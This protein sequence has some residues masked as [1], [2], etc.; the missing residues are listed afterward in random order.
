VLTIS[1]ETEEHDE[2]T[3]RTYL[4]RERRFGARCVGV[5]FTRP[6]RLRESW[7]GKQVENYIAADDHRKAA[8]VSGREADQESACC[9]RR[10][11]PGLQ[12]VHAGGGTR[13]PDT[14]IMM[15]ARW[16]GLLPGVPCFAC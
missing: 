1:G 9:L 4:H 6:S 13:T 15:L 8:Q 7:H 3:G 2:E 10:K 11:L 5:W 16:F 14:R 12:A